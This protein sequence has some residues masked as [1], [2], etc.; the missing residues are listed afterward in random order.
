MA[1]CLLAASPSVSG[2]L[3]N[4]NVTITAINVS[5]GIVLSRISGR[6]PCFF[7]VSASNITATGTTAPYE[8]LEYSWDFGDPAGIEI[9]ANPGVGQGSANANN[10]QRGPEAA[11]GYRSPGTYTITLTVRGLNGLALVK[12]TQTA[13]VTVTAFPTTNQKYLDSAAAD[14]GDGSIG[15]PWNVISDANTYLDAGDDRLLSIKRGSV[16]PGTVGLTP[17]STLSTSRTGLRINAYGTGAKPKIQITSGGNNAL[18]MRS[19]TGTRSD[20][21]FSDIEFAATAVTA[22]NSTVDITFVGSGAVGDL[23]FDNCVS[24][25]SNDTS[26]DF[27]GILLNGSTASLL[28]RIGFWNCTV[29]SPQVVAGSSDNVGIYW[30]CQD[31]AFVIAGSISGGTATASGLEHHI[32]PIIQTHALFRYIAFGQGPNR[33]YCINTDWNQVSASLEYSEFILFADC[34]MTGVLRAHDMS[35]GGSN[36]PTKVLYRNA[37][38]ERNR[39]HDLGGDGVV[40]F[41][42]GL[43]YTHRDNLA[44]NNAGAAGGG[45][46]FRPQ[47]NA[48]IITRVYRNKIYCAAHSNPG[49]IFAYE[50]AAQTFNQLQ[51]NTDNVI[52]DMRSSTLPNIISFTFSNQ[53]GATI[54]RNRYYAPNASDS[55]YL[56]NGSTR[57][58]LADMQ[59]AGFEAAGVY[60]NPNWPDPAVGN[61]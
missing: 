9:F 53:A 41:F 46:Y 57:D 31:W 60:G 25:Q 56:Y 23:Y 8:D 52:Q 6:A 26:V 22:A 55:K 24:T 33:N 49:A 35:E 42:C 27:T 18:Y 15:T 43:S 17:W 14:G 59:G 11:Y 37:V 16:F 40:Y 13:T 48:N 36:D 61:F 29:T 50:V 2:F 19:D 7:Q 1:G 21:V 10:H 51:T 54:N 4:P 34:E 39:I 30:K 5:G 47:G 38:C 58:T 12:A 45:V 44:W 20:I 3:G 28:N 32:Y